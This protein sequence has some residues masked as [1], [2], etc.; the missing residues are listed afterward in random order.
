MLL[1]CLGAAQPALGAPNAIAAEN[2]RAGTSEW[3]VEPPAQPAIEGY[4]SES[5]VPPGGAFHLHVRAPAGSR[6]RIAIYRLGWYGGAGGRLLRCL[7]A[8]DGDSPAVPQ[9]D[10]PPPD[11]HTGSV[12]AGWRVTDVLPVGPDWVSGY[13]LA[14]LR[15][16]AGPDA[17]AVGRVPLIVRAPP[18]DHAAIA[19]QVPVNTWQAYNGW[20]G[21]SLYPHNST[22]RKP[23]V[24]VSFN[25]P[26]SEDVPV[27]VPFMLELPALHFIER[28]G[29]DVSY[30]TDVDVDR[31]PGL[32]LRHRAAV[33]I[34]HDEYWSG[35]MRAAWS[36]ALRR[37]TNLAALG[38]N[39]AYWQVR[40]EHGHRTLVEYRA[41]A[42]DP[43]RDRAAQTVEFRN[44][45]RPEC[46][47][48][49]VEYEVYA[50]RGWNGPPTD[51]RVVARRGDPW[52]RGTGLANG[53][54]LHGLVGYEWDEL[55]PGCFAGRITRLL[56]AHP[57][58]VDGKRH[59]ADAVRGLSVSGARVFSAGSLELAWGLDGAPAIPAVQRLVG[60][61]FAD[62][63]RAPAPGGVKLEVGR[64][65]VTVSAPPRA[66]DPRLRR[67]VV[68]RHRGRERFD[69]TDP[70]AVL[71]CK[72]TRARCVDRPPRGTVRYAA[73]NADRWGR[74]APV[75]SRAVSR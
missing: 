57:V 62:L 3:D 50:Q 10:P 16:T 38:A 20:G 64:R 67:L 44:L 49:G 53:D 39:E 23:A 32:L 36:S 68:Y 30:V 13:Y 40:Y 6:Y 5:S 34:G 21:K 63:V 70:T 29:L 17:G 26:Y 22:R 14:Q 61:V 55:V 75:W 45:H 41:A 27:K 25:R 51:Y 72:S 48:F 1:A 60:N 56:H 11:P 2:A 15:V 19:V 54:V 58:G 9:P 24:K 73:E 47:L 71:V 28:S 35:A 18:R 59:S 33:S 74:S 66:R 7:P 12:D 37:S 69:P 31:D 4:V 46:E 42:R 52:L 43:Q 65:L 8:C